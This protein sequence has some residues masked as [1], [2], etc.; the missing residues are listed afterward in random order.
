MLL[1]YWPG[2]PL[3]IRLLSAWTA[4]FP[5][6]AMTTVLPW[7]LSLCFF[8]ELMVKD[9]KQSFW[10]FNLPKNLSIETSFDCIWSCTVHCTMYICTWSTRLAAMN[11]NIQ[12]MCQWADHQQNGMTPLAHWLVGA[13]IGAGVPS[14]MPTVVFTNKM[15]KAKVHTMYFGISST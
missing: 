10:P 12:K 3:S 4:I 9:W 13:K 6:K 5:Q 15:S 14:P 1:S 2:P 8:Y 7:L 11:Q